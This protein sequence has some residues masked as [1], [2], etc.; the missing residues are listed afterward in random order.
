MDPLSIVKLIGGLGLFIY[1]MIT[2]GNALEKMAGER[3]EKTLE[4]VTG[5]LFKAIGLGAVV[6]G[7]IQSSSAT[8]VMIVGF[9]NAGIMNLTQA[10]GVI[11]GANIGTTVTSQLL[12][13]DTTGAVKGSLIMQLLNPSMLAYVAVAIG[14]VLF[15][16]SKKKK[17]H[18]FG[19]ILLGFGILFIGMSIMEGSVASLKDLPWFQS[20]FSTFTNPV[21]G[22]LVGVAVTA[23]IQSSSASV[24]ILQAVASTGAITYGAAIPIIMGQNIG[25]C[26]TALLSSLGANKNAKRAAMI[27]FYF[28]LI[29]SIVFIV[30]VY[31]I[32]AIIGFDFW[33]DPIGKAGIANFH[34]IFN[35][36]STLIFIPFH[37]VLIFLAEKTI[38]T[39]ASDSL[40][41]EELG[42]LD[43]RFYSSPVVALDQCNKIIKSMGV[44]AYKN[45]K[46][47]NDAI[48]ENKAPHLETFND[49]ETFLD[50]AEARLNSYMIGIKNEELSENSKKAYAE[51]MHTIGDFERVGDYAENLLEFYQDMQERGIAFSE[52]AFGELRI[53]SGAVDEILDLT[54]RAYNETDAAIARQVEPLEDVIDSIKE[55]LKSR[56][57]MRL[58]H[59][60]CTINIGIPFLDIIHNYEKI[61]DHCSN[62]AVYIMMLADDAQEFDIHEYRKI[63]KD[64][65]TDEFQA[66]SSLYENK[67]LNKVL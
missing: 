48:V 32:K 31:A 39:D 19:E 11:M 47:V 49:N 18:D 2:M 45:I 37:K 64:I 25:T 10:V 55:A 66:F 5:N 28:N 52:E 22:V 46:I 63:V 58:Q 23:I 67:Y 50:R 43:E 17:H 35:I 54:T 57:I 13:L 56:H 59:G 60:I 12:R 33:G 62:I 41:G 42:R 24:G 51:M 30:G 40:V 7:I 3:L 26:I 29:G 34:L 65:R 36:A 61:A 16:F 8:T 9:V 38:K 14:A 44:C 27:H 20:M 15:M 4:S 1:G 21:I 53:M 6:T